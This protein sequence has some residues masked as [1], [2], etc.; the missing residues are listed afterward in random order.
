[1][2]STSHGQFDESAS[3]RDHTAPYNQKHQ[4]PTI[5]G[6]Q[7]R[8]EERQEISE[9]TVPEKV[10]REAPKD[11]ED[12]SLLDSAKR[13]FHIGS[14]VKDKNVDEQHPYESH[15]RNLQSPEGQDRRA[16]ND[17]RGNAE[18]G[19]LAPYDQSEKGNGHIKDGE[20]DD[21]REDYQRKESGSMLHDTSEAIDGTLDPKAKRKNMKKMKRD[22]AAR[23]VTD[24]VTHLRV[25]IHD[26]TDKELKTVPENE[27]PGGSLAR[28][29]TGASAVSKSQSQLETEAHEQ[30]AEHRSMEK[31]FPPPE[32]D[33]ARQ[34]I[35]KVYGLAFTVGLGVLLVTMMVSLSTSHLLQGISSGPRSWLYLL[36]S[37]SIMLVMGSAVGG[38]TIWALGGW[39]KSRVN[40]IFEDEV[41]QSARKQEEE[42]ADSPMPE[43]TQ[44][45]NS[46]L[47][48]V[49]PLINPDL[50]ASLADTVEDVMQASLPKL[51]RM[52]S[53]EDIG[54]GSESI[55]I[56]GVRWLPTG[57]AAKNVSQDGKIKSRKE[58]KNS[59]RKVPG[60]GEVDSDEKSDDEGDHRPDEQGKKDGGDE[61]RVEGEEQNI[62]E[63]MEAEEGDFV[64]VEVGFSYRASKSG[65]SLK[66][67][68]KKA[69]L[70]LA[71]YLP[72]GIRFPVWVELRGI[73]GTLRMRLQLCPDP[74][75]FALCTLT[76]L[77]QPKAEMSCVPLTKKGLNIMDF[78]LISSFVQSSID[79]AL[80]EY[81]APKSL[82]LDLKD[83]LVG[84][85]FKKDTVTR[86]VVMVTIKRG[87]DFKE[88]DPGIVGL[89]KGSSDAYVAVGWAKF[90]KPVW[91]T[92]VIVKDM[93]PVWEETAFILVG[94]QEVN[95]EERLRVQLWDSDRTSADDDLG[96]IEVDLKELMHSHQSHSKIWHRT[97]GFQALEGDEKMPGT[98]DWSVGYFPKTRIQQ[99]QLEKQKVEPEINT[100]RKLKEKVSED[101]RKKLREAK[102]R[103]ESTET[104]QQKAQMLK[105]R[106]DAMIIS[107]P[108][109]QD[110]PTGVYSIQIHQITSLEFEKINKSQAE[111]DEGDET[112][113]GSGDLPSSY[114]NIILNHQTIFKTRTKPKNAQPFFNAGIERLIRDWRTTEIML[115]VRDSRVHENDVSYSFRV[116]PSPCVTT[117][118]LQ[119][120]FYE[121][122]CFLDMSL[123]QF[124]VKKERNADSGILK[125][126][127]GMVYLPLGKLLKDRSQI[128]DEYPLVGGIGY[129]RVRISMV[130][131]SIQLQVPKQLL[132]WDY[133]TVEITGPITSKDIASDLNELRLKVRTTVNRGKM[134]SAKTDTGEHCWVG[135]RGRPV[136]IAVKKRYSSCL[137]VEFRRN[138][139]GFDKTSAFAVLWLKDIPDEE[140]SH[141]TLPVW[142]GDSEKLK[143]AD[144]NCTS[145]DL[146]KQAGTIKI[147]LKFYRGLGAYHHKLASHSPTLQDVLEVLST[148]NDNQE[149]R[150]AMAGDEDSSAS[151]SD[152]SDDEGSPK[153]ATNGILKKLKPS[154]HDTDKD[155]HPGSGQ[156]DQIRDYKAGSEQL[157]RRHRGLMQ[158]K[159]A[160][161]GKYF[162]TKIEHGRD[163][164][165]DSFRHHDRDPGIETEV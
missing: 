16:S 3:R 153:H 124:F 122:L 116:M 139:L 118:E 76:L 21:R 27:P 84:D 146:G 18:N 37:S 100:V 72:G 129:G 33:A 113:A 32:F 23:E 83:M 145:D 31:L 42:T 87:I 104:D 148:A 127:L 80:A 34:E 151:D 134:Y 108:P 157:H 35:A 70:F 140:E 25:M 136:R 111:G 41:W 51:V 156:V 29:A 63:G 163:H 15:N 103:D 102:D 120:M 49:W 147:P 11:G 144:S 17:H 59:D 112:E 98:L 22:H 119:G 5:A 107:T 105:D 6:Y 43:S 28:S 2:S 133:G 164:V 92:R 154:S 135:K 55:R 14:P 78:P 9:A 13:H 82:T 36:V 20:E 88:G 96:R 114:C 138:Q 40:T 137:V 91:S 162:K 64:N 30:Q 10:E 115:S 77:G 67:K 117:S 39:L 99:E 8:K 38:A 149:V 130:F 65:K 97:D 89:K 50:F 24:P 45:L 1:M 106:E 71:F 86:G 110:Y 69:H 161:T 121:L 68:S 159:V 7:E 90:G 125:P 75:F 128:M 52:V 73:V 12:E 150:T 79:A 58:Q 74:P 165:M 66:L 47:S 61:K 143:R 160:R 81:V 44:W 123:N 101:A 131:R 155:C 126:L 95:A 142:R 46:I 26:T 132:G 62:A 48:S 54:Q 56:L 4:I 60:Q 109:S 94:A 53:V 141:I 19:G 158:W 152:S 85:D 93:Q 57:A